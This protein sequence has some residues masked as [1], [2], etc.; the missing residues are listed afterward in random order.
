LAEVV[1]EDSA[2]AAK[3]SDLEMV[4]VV[5]EMVALPAILEMELLELQTQ[6]E[7]EAEQALMLTALLQ[8]LM[9]ALVVQVTHELLFGVNYGTTLCIS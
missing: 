3:S 6:A 4:A 8:L 1:V 7:A 5:V 2:Q 9:V